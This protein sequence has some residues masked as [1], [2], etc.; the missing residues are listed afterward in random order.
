MTACVFPDSSCPVRFHDT[1][2]SASTQVNKLTALVKAEMTL[3]RRE[4]QI[5]VQYQETTVADMK[6]SSL[7]Y[8]RVYH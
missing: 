1:Y 4:I 3:F 5:Q 6:I 7:A 2:G 8:H